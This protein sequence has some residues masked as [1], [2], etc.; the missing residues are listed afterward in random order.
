MPHCPNCSYI[1]VLLEHR[2]R[3]KCS[4]CSRLYPQKQIDN[5]EFCKWNE[6]HRNEAYKKYLNLY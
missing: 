6:Q 4:K 1:L 3:Y 2:M 5:E